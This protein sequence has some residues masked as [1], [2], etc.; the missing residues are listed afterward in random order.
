MIRRLLILFIGVIPTLMLAQDRA[1]TVF[2]ITGMV[3]SESSDSA[4]AYARIQVNHSRRGALANETGFYSIAVN[5]RDTLYFS[6]IGYHDSRLIVSEYVKG[7]KGDRSQYIYAVN[8]M[9]E[10]TFTLREVVIFPYD[11]PEELR[12][13]IV[14]LGSMETAMERAAR[15]NLDPA[16][17]DAI[18]RELPIDGNERIMVARQM[19]YNQYQQQN[20][21]QTAAIDPVAAA[22]LLQ[23]IVEKAKTRKRR[24]LNYWTD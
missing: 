10:D 6:H 8:Y 3:V 16:R 5:L 12:T 19:Y 13:A 15:E 2:Q 22:R 1:N 24:D 23:M 9:L 17:L 14:N 21:L 20:L 18:M 7:Y 4:I 11:T